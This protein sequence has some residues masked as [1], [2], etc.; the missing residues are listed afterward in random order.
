M[1]ASL[2]GPLR[3]EAAR[4]SHALEPLR[5]G[6]TLSH[7]ALLALLLIPQIATVL[8]GQSNKVA[9]KTD[10]KPILTA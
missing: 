1:R 4:R 5:S 7:C 8:R 6:D 10:L 2:P 3:N 9:A